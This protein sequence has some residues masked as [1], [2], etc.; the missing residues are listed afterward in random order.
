MGE[1]GRLR[2]PVP[3]ECRLPSSP[4]E[5]EGGK[6]TNQGVQGKGSSSLDQSFYQI[7]IRRHISHHPSIAQCTRQ[8]CG[9][10]LASA[11]AAAA[12][13]LSSPLIYLSIP[14]LRFSPKGSTAAARAR[15]AP[16]TVARCRASTEATPILKRRHEVDRPPSTERWRMARLS[17]AQGNFMAIGF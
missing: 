9:R 13:S 15:P 8:F 4:I 17:G 3:F 12:T 10:P 2:V 16:P 14:S 11:A 6:L 5:V 1:E 7:E